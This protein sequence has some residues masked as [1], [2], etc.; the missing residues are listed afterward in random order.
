MVL[1][2]ALAVVLTS[3]AQARHERRAGLSGVVVGDNP[4]DCPVQ[5][6]DRHLVRCDWLTGAGAQA[7]LSVTVWH[8]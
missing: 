7:P 4:R 6:I 3:P 8:R 2:L 5:R 1:V